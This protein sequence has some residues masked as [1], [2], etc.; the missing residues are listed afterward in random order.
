MR[1]ALARALFIQPTLLLL[2]ET[3]TSSLPTL[4]KIRLII[5]L[6][7]ALIFASIIHITVLVILFIM[8]ANIEF[9]CKGDDM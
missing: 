6:I 5:A 1:I 8:T 7:V 2:G 4:L 3:H 9:W